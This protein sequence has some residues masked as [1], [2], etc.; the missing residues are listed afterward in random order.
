MHDTPA[1]ESDYCA[2]LEAPEND[3]RYT[4]GVDHLMRHWEKSGR[5][6]GAPDVLDLGCGTGTLR[7]FLPRSVRFTGVDRDAEALAV[8]RQRFPGDEFVLADNVEFCRDHAVGPRR[9]D[10]VALAGVLFHNVVDDDGAHHDDALFL[11]AVRSVLGLN[12][13]LMV[14]APFAYTTGRRSFWEQAQWKH[15]EVSAVLLRA[16][17]DGVPVAHE[18]IT[19]QIGL[20]ERIAAQ[21]ERPRWFVE[22]DEE[23][24]SRFRGHHLATL[25]LVLADR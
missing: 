11:R 4:S 22:A 14:L 1:V 25:T 18:A 21:R 7:R 6:D 17:P 13:R 15:D 16:W 23:P 12:G 20:A 10:A 5:H 8:A 9:W 19:C 24:E 2:Y 3:S